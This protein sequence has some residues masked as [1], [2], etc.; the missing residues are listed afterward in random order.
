MNASV[1]HPLAP[2]AEAAARLAVEAFGPWPRIAPL[3]NG[4]GAGGDRHREW[5][6]LLARFVREDCIE[7]ATMARV[8]RLVEVYLSRLAEQDPDTFADADEQLAFF[9]NAYN[10]I[11]V[12]QVLLHYPVPS[13]RS[14]GGAWGRPY[15]IGR[16]NLSLLALEAGILRAFGDPRVHAAITPAALGASSLQPRAFSGAELQQQLDESVRG[17]LADQRRGA[18]YDAVMDVLWLPAPL[19]RYAGDWILPARMPSAALVPLGRLKTPA[20]LPRL[21]PYLPDDIVAM[22]GSSTSIRFAAFDW[23]LNDTQT[24]NDQR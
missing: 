7:Y 6:A 23:S 19:Q 21:V 17:L 2:L 24:I 10:T 4:A 5:S 15:P 14:I 1:P 20:M 13:L 22:I 3:R 11:A 9:L 18:G 16:R 8:R 12:H